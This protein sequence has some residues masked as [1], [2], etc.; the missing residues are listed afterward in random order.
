[1]LLGNLPATLPLA[2]GEAVSMVYDTGGDTWDPA[3]FYRC[4]V[5]YFDY[6][7]PDDSQWATCEYELIQPVPVESAS[8]GAV[9]S[10]YR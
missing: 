8:W 2:P 1:M 4:V 10:L 9:K 3:G 6:A 5:P 7:Y